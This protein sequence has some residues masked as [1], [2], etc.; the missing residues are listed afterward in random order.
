MKKREIGIGALIL[1]GIAFLLWILVLATG[2]VFRAKI[3]FFGIPTVFY[4]SLIVAFVCLIGDFIKFIGKKFSEGYRPEQN[5]STP[6][7]PQSTAGVSGGS[8]ETVSLSANR[9]CGQCGSPV[10][11]GDAFCKKC[12][13]KL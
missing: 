13:T 8:S 6:V 4:V 12:G 11:E 5:V 3:L 10:D 7:Q 2:L 1:A 9:F